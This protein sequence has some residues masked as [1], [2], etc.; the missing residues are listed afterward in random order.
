MEAEGADL[1]DIGGEST[2][3]GAE[4]VTARGGARPRASGSA[5]PRR[6]PADSRVRRHLQSRSRTRGHRC[7]RRASSTTSAA[8]AT[9]RRSRGVVAEGGRRA[10]LDAHARAPEPRCTPRRSTRTS[11]RRWPLSSARGIARATAA[12][13][14]VDRVIVD[15]G[16]G[17]AKRPAHS[18]GV[19]ARLPELAAALDRPVLVGPSRKSFLRRSASAAGRRLSAT[20]EPRPP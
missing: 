1:I 15:P 4:P 10:R 11:W 18:Y 3:P 16:I 2:R 5:R 9:I 14:A 20:G 8:F 19:L 17:F 12:G 6:T 7:R 13:V